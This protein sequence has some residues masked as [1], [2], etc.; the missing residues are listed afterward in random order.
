MLVRA[1]CEKFKKNGKEYIRV[2]TIDLSSIV[3]HPRF[4]FGVL[5]NGNPQLDQDLHKIIDDNPDDF[6]EIMRPTCESMFSIAFLEVFNS[7]FT[8][9]PL[10]ELFMN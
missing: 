2:L 8:H 1:T 5:I 3:R 7:V 10:E 6:F 4:D 9:I